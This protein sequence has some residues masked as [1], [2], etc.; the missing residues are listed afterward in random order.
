MVEK[1]PLRS[2]PVSSL[3]PFGRQ[4]ALERKEVEPHGLPW[5]PH[6]R[7]ASS[8]VLVAAVSWKEGVLFAPDP[9]AVARTSRDS[10][11]SLQGLQTVTPTATAAVRR[12]PIPPAVVEGWFVGA[13]PGSRLPPRLV[14]SPP[15]AIPPPVNSPRLH[16][17]SLSLT[18]PIRFNISAVDDASEELGAPSSP[19]FSGYKASPKSKAFSPLTRQSPSRLR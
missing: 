15:V 13:R 16:H 17:I 1:S 19:P 3:P 5:L 9:T 2:S 11:I 6:S 10:V 12:G 14:T 7:L 8:R 18:L 4:D